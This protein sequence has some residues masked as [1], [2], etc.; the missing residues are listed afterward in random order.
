M[1][2]KNKKA[3]SFGHPTYVFL[4]LILTLGTSYGDVNNVL[5]NPG[6]EY[7][8]TGW[9]ARGSGVTI[10]SGSSSPSPYSGSYRGRATGRTAT[11]MG[12][13]QDVKNKMVIGQTYPISGWVRTSSATNDTVK[14]SVQK[15]DGGGTTYVN[16]ATV[17]ANNSKWYSLSGSYTLTVNDTLTELLVYFETQ[18]SGIIDIY[19]D[20]ANVFGQVPATADPNATGQVNFNVTHQT[21]EGFGAAGAWYEGWLTA[22]PQKTTLY[23]ILFRDLG[24]DI[25]RVRNC[26]GFDGGYIN[27]TKQIVQAA[28]TRNPSLK[29][30]NCAWSPPAYLKSNNDTNSYPL[31]GTL[32]K[33]ANDS[34]NSAPYYYVYK[35][36][37]KWWADSLAAYESNS[38]HT[39]YMSIQNEGDFETDYESCKFLPTETSSYASYNQAFEAVYQKLNSVMGPNMP[40]ML[41]PETMGFGGAQAYIN[42]LIDVNHVY[43]YAHH[44][45]SDGDYD[46]PDSFVPGMQNFGSLYGYKP[47]FQTEYEKLSGATDDFSAAMNMALHMHNSLVCEGVCSYFHWCLFWG[48]SGG[49]VTLPTYGG[50]SYIINPT[51]Y[52]MQHYSKFTDP[53]W[54]RVDANSSDSTNLRISAYKDPCEPNA[55]IVVINT[56]TTT[57]VNLTLSL[58]GFTPQNSGIYQSKS[59]A[60][61]AYIGTFSTSTPV[62]LPKQ[63]I[64]T[65]HLAGI[66][67]CADVQAGNYKLDSDLNGDCYVDLL[68]LEIMANY[69]LNT[70]CAISGN[71]QGAD[72]A[73]TDGV[74]DF[75][76]FADFGPQWRQCNNPQ[77]ANCTPNW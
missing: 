1:M 26:Y 57:D 44:L 47:L 11:W 32:K 4:I 18:T 34:N 69:W 31:P 17:T 35:A 60:N 61:F 48:G 13:Q 63:S 58:N 7:G 76:D 62:F 67:N 29:I 75:F 42:A 15:T 9:A 41:A 25:Y 23:N 65:I 70:N 3:I 30:L 21:L 50:S 54:Q 38:I 14:M 2:K 24:L 53:N 66:I 27:T 37:A 64:T 20:D 46:Y 10:S 6:F 51:Y 39:D 28:K 45:Y 59:N 36:Y 16:V 55:A 71:C 49:L 68:D 19:V 72:F 12:I 73:P 33:D 5:T 52:V 8:T 77:D 43:G 56:S 40:K 22:H 74:V